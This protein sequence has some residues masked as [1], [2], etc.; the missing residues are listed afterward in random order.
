MSVA[1]IFM[2]RS[3]EYYRDAFDLFAY[4]YLL[5]PVT[6][7]TLEYIMEPLKKRLNI[8]TDERVIH[9]QYRAR[10]YTLRHSQVSFITSSLHIVNFHMTDGSILQCRGKLKDFEKQLENSTFL[11]CHQ[12]FI[13]NM[14]RIT[15]AKNDSF[16]IGDHVIP[17]SRSYNRVAH[18]KY[19]EYLRFQ[20]ECNGE[21]T[22]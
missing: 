5:K 14:E 6:A 3:D 10:V 16:R 22:E 11:R 17:I 18:E 19:D 20:Q 13:I 7:A 21:E 1:V 9:F 15:G 12:S 8:N 2:S 4:N